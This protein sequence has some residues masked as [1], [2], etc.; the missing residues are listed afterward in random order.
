MI[1]RLRG[2]LAV[3]ALSIGFGLPSAAMAQVVPG[4]EH[5]VVNV[6]SDDVLNMREEPSSRSEIVAQK[7]YGQ[8]GILVQ[9]ACQGSWCP[10]EDGHSQGWVN[11]RFIS[12][13]SP[14]RY[15]V[16]GVA[17]GDT[18]N[19]RAWPSPQSRVLAK[20]SRRQCNIA[21]LPYSRGSWQKIRVGGWEGWVNR[22][23]VSGQ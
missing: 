13:V 14:S 19:L 6:A 4:E 10:V 2:G 17:Q 20:L 9:D 1:D 18:L 5:C 15:C 23:Y 22:R 3:L 8:C 12:M 11:R 21:F 16:S 7:R